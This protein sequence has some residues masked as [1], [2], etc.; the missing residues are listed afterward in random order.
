RSREWIDLLDSAQG[1]RGLHINLKEWTMPVFEADAETPRVR[2]H[3]KLPRCPL[4]QGHMIASET[5]IGPDHPCGLHAS[6][7][8]G[9]PIPPQAI[10]DPR[11]DAHMVVVDP[12]EGRA[13]DFWQCRREADGSWHTN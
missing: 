9:V 8:D 6:V 4:S 10:P 3:A 12:E 11:H 13:Y 1:G 2:L 7:R 5:K